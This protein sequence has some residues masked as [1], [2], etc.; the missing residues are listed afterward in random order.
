[1]ERGIEHKKMRIKAVV[2]RLTQRD[3]ERFGE[4][5]SSEP[6][7]TSASQRRGANVRAAI[8]A[9][10]FETLEPAMTVDQVGDQEPAV[11]KFLGDWIDMVYAEVTNIPP[12]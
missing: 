5:I 2:K 10:W 7:A 4:A 12:D 3:L 8:K 1:M 11:V 9:E 6:P